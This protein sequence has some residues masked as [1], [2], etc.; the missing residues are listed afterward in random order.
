MAYSP[1]PVTVVYTSPSLAGAAL[2][3][4]RLLRA[5]SGVRGAALSLPTLVGSGGGDVKLCPADGPIVP[6]VALALATDAAPWVEELANACPRLRGVALRAAGDAHVYAGD[7]DAHGVHADAIAGAA[8]AGAADAIAGA[9]SADPLPRV[10]TF[11]IS[12]AS[13]RGVRCGVWTWARLALGAAATLGAEHV[14]IAAPSL[15]AALLRAAVAAPSTTAVPRFAVRGLFPWSNFAMGA[16]SF[17]AG[18]WRA[19]VASLSSLRLNTLQL[20]NYNDDDHRTYG[21][22]PFVWFG[23]QADILPDGAVARAHAAWHFTNLNT[24]DHSSSFETGWARNTSDFDGGAGSLYPADCFGSPLQTGLLD[25]C[26]RPSTPSAVTGLFADAARF[27]N[28]SVWRPARAAGVSLSVAVGVPLSLPAPRDAVW[29]PVSGHFCASLPFIHTGSEAPAACAALCAAMQCTCFDTG[30]PPAG[31]PPPNGAPCRITLLGNATAPSAWDYT[32]NARAIAGGAAAQLAAYTGT[33][34]RLASAYAG[35][36][37]TLV[38]WA[39]IASTLAD[40]EAV[41]EELPIAAAARDALGLSL[42]LATGGWNLGPPSNLTFLD[43]VAAPE[44]T[45]STLLPGEG[46][47]DEPPSGLAA[48]AHHNAWT[49]PWLEGDNG[50]L[51]P[52]LWVHRTLRQLDEGAAARRV[53][54]ALAIHW[55]VAQCAPAATALALGAWAATT[56]QDAFAEYVSAAFGLPRGGA[57]ALEPLRARIVDAFLALDGNGSWTGEPLPQ[58]SFDA[59]SGAAPTSDASVAATWAFVERTWEPLAAEAAHTFGVPLR[60]T[61]RLAYWIAQWRAS[62]AK[63]TLMLRARDWSAVW[64][65]ITAAPPAQ[66]AG[67]AETRGLPALTALARAYD[68]IISPLLGAADTFG[69]IG[70]LT[71]VNGATYPAVASAA[72]NLRTLVDV[73]PD[74]LPNKTYAGAPHVWAP[75]VAPSAPSGGAWAVDVWTISTSPVAGAQLC[76]VAP[77][78]APPACTPMSHIAGGVWRGSLTMG[79]RG[80]VL[81]VYATVALSDGTELRLPD[82]APEADVWT[83][84]AEDE[85]E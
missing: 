81:D 60:A 13:P 66:R 51:A 65:A 52:Q 61:R 17:D 49:I 55:R 47:G 5:A 20:H 48:V 50:L 56:P 62:R 19:Y 7:S 35:G 15:G 34:A 58:V 54:G 59:S 41:V 27:Y 8:A 70:V 74:A 77:S 69:D 28:A 46:S 76:V 10:A 4:A 57:P 14:P 45:L 39:Q 79:A 21:V 22:Q 11:V 24:F 85:S 3:A 82:G 64:A 9:A 38:L 23:E 29:A 2:E 36:A 37:D 72:A 43:S 68:A 26:P 75:G 40:F 73:P 78:P 71:E 1:P 30:T 32:A 12:A 67:L 18:A 31:Q 33:L 25:R 80:T 84:L 16:D 44:V 42:G 6:I 63:Q 83:V 53:T